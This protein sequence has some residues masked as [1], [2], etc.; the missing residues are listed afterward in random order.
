MKLSGIIVLLV[1]LFAFSDERNDAY[2][3]IKNESFSRG[4]VLHYKMSYG[5]LNIGKG[6]VQIH[7]N[8]FN[9]N[10]RQ[11]YKLDV[12]GKTVGVVDWVADVD[13]QWGAYIDTAA[14]VP[15]IS[16]RKI[17]EGK[18]R[19]DEVVNFDHQKQK[20]EVKLIDQKT[21]KYKEPKYYDYEK[22]AQMRD[23]IA[24]FLYLRTLNL[25]G[26]KP[27]DSVLVK[28]FFED[29]FYK[30]H[31]VYQGKSTIKTK[32]GKVKCLVFK[33]VMPNNKVFDGENSITVWFS[34]DK[35]RIPIKVSAKMFIGSA[36]VELTSY[37]ALRNPLNLVN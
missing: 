32:V 11:C 36:G 31:I 16:Y 15:H 24:G 26:V 3:V 14:L 4:E 22:P 20:I 23:M 9:V 37:G 21:G 2:Q 13:D 27:G 29:E 10:N 1:A 7:E 17:R 19:K 35:N 8:F 18:Y 33:P 28:G 6:T 30:M 34:D 5:F 25:T 12:F